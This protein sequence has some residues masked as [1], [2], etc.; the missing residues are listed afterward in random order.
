VLDSD[1]GEAQPKAADENAFSSR[2]QGGA[3]R[4]EPQTTTGPR[5]RLHFPHREEPVCRCKD[6]EGPEAAIQEPNVGALRNNRSTNKPKRSTWYTRPSA[7]MPRRRPR[8]AKPSRSGLGGSSGP[9]SQTRGFGSMLAFVP[10][11]LIVVGFV[12]LGVVLLAYAFYFLVIK[13]W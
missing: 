8:E 3:R 11:T 1:W 10:G 12:V 2:T 4:C 6:R 7:S 9:E 5:S 13:K